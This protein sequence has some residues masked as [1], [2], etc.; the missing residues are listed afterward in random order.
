MTFP[1]NGRLKEG[2]GQHRRKCSKETESDNTGS[3]MNSKCQ[4]S[5]TSDC[6]TADMALI[7]DWSHAGQRRA[8]KG[9]LLTEITKVAVMKRMKLSQRKSP[10]KKDAHMRGTPGGISQH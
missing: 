3:A 6:G 8:E 1:K 7:G 5:K 2:T 10:W 9:R 4:W